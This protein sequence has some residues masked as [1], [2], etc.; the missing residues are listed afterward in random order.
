M[1]PGEPNQINGLGLM[2]SD[3]KPGTFSIQVQSIERR[4]LGDLDPLRHAAMDYDACLPF[5]VA[6]TLNLAHVVFPPA[7]KR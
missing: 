6:V 3:K 5:R 2:R 4:V 1:G 7:D